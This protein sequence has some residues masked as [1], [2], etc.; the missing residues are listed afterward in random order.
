MTTQ[1]T[2]RVADASL[3]ER[4]AK[5]DQDALAIL[6]RE[7]GGPVYSLALRI[8]VDPQLAQE[9]V[10]DV[11]IAL[12]HHAKSYDHHTA[13][14]AS[15]VLGYARHKAIDRV[16]HEERRKPRTLDGR[17]ATSVDIEAVEIIDEDASADP[18]A[19]AWVALQSVEVVQALV[20]LSAQHREVLELAYFGGYSQTEI[21][22]SISVP[23]GT[24]KTRTIRALVHLR[25]ILVTRGL[26]G[27]HR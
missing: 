18:F 5:G 19:A 23:V 26:E 4:M 20:E 15:W 21:A 12:W 13:S 1:E 17:A 9:A 16:R 10:Q 7:L 22:A 27:N 11:F 6:M 24:V 14:V 2:P 25:D 3:V 8:T